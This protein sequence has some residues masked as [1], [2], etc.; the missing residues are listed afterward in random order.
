VAYSSAHSIHWNKALVVRIPASVS[1]PPDDFAR[2]H[3]L[4]GPQSS[5]RHLSGGRQGYSLRALCS[6]VM[7]KIFGA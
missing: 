3:S 6:F 1:Y 2:A 7:L 4:H 5:F